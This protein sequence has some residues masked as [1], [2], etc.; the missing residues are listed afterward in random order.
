MRF[1]QRVSRSYRL[2]FRGLL[3]HAGQAYQCKTREEILQVA[4]REQEI[5][6]DVRLTLEKNGIEVKEISVG[7]TPTVLVSDQ[8][9]SITEIR[10]GNYV[11]MDRTPLRF[12]LIERHEIALTLFATIV[13]KNRDY[14]IIDAGSKMIS[15][16]AA[17]HGF[18]QEDGF[19]L[20]YPAE[21]FPSSGS[22]MILAKLSEEHGLVKRGDLDLSI[23]S[24]VRIIP[25]HACVVSNL[26]DW[27]TVVEGE[28]VVDR[29]RI[30][31][32]GLSR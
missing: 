12:G 24:Q 23:G 9:E 19:G 5:L 16:D 27:F 18:S 7:S 6:T 32:R 31:A 20:V 14:F 26:S 3:S 22:E 17:G 10:P 25:N 15:S 1:A 21:R 29:W 30:A 28:K 2:D 4:Y 13:S 11:F 8:Y